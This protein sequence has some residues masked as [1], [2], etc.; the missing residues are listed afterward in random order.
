MLYFGLMKDYIKK[1][2]L[3]R[4]FRVQNGFQTGYSV[5]LSAC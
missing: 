3:I 5:G 4:F 1:M 2:V